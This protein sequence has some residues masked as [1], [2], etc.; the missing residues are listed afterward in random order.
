MLNVFSN[1]IDKHCHLFVY[2]FKKIFS[3][4][5]KIKNFY[6]RFVREKLHVT[7]KYFRYS[8]FKE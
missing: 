1:I 6:N 4:Y 2:L 3:D 7:I 5:E 8:K